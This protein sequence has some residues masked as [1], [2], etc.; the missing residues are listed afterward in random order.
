MLKTLISVLRKPLYLSL[1]SIVAWLI[2]SVSILFPNASLLWQVMGSSSMT[3]FAKIQFVATF[4]GALVTN[5]TPF[6]ATYTI[7]ISLLF[8]INVSLLVFYIR[9]QRS[10]FKGVG[11]VSVA[12]VGGLTAGFLG[13]GCAA[14]GTFVLTSLLALIGAGSILTILPL[15]GQEL[16]VLAVGLLAYSVY[17]LIKKINAPLIC[18]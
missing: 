3:L 18:E 13:I 1:T 17:A 14:C 12:G 11:H 8:A 10:I 6:S 16:G 4:Y 5:F 9:R 7:L 2:L 15:K